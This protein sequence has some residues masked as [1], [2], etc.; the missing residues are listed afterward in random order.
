MTDLIL[1]KDPLEMIMEATKSGLDLQAIEKMMDLQEAFEKKEAKKA[2]IVA[3]AEFK[4][5]PI[6]ISKDKVNTQFKSKY[7]SIGNLV[8]TV[9]PR[10]SECGFSHNWKVEQK[11]NEIKVTCVLTHELGHSE[12]VTMSSPPDSSGS[13]NAI[14]QI[15]SARTYLQAA[16]FESLLG[17]ASTD[18]NF[19]DDGNSANQ[20]TITDHQFA[21]LSALMQEKSVDAKGF[22]GYFKI[23]NIEDLPAKSYK[24]AIKMIEQKKD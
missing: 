4:K 17:L 7:T 2:F 23:K 16:T 14:Q 11:E 12:E 18:A 19:D 1:K 6:Q 22:C 10:L 20:E 24:T 13:K 3:M 21:E 15:K 9:L 5:E 8:N